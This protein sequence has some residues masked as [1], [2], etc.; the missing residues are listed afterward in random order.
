M[1]LKFNIFTGKFDVVKGSDAYDSRFFIVDT[2]A[3]ILASTP[4]NAKIGLATDTDEMYLYDTNDDEWKVASLEL[5][6]EGANP[7][8]GY[9][10]ENDKLGY[11]SDAIT[12]KVLSWVKLG[13]GAEDE[14]GAL[15]QVD[16]IF[17]IYLNGAWNDVVINFVFREDSSGGYELEHQPVGFEW[18]YEV[19]SGN[20]GDYFDLNGLPVV[21]QYTTS[22]G[23]YQPKLQIDGGTF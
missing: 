12:D 19:M 2:K 13:S 18:Y 15:R 9:T 23:C 14:E 16:G 6:A 11:H 8:M 20:S 1:S 22:M 3:T 10:Q 7:D 4:T 17:Q 21:Q 5:K